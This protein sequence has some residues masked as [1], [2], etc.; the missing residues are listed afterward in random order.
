MSLSD[1][2]GES[3]PNSM[4][5]NWFG[6]IELPHAAVAVVLLD[7]TLEDLP[8]Y[9]LCDLRIDYLP[10]FI[11]SGIG[12]TKLQTHFK[13]RL[14]KNLCNILKFNYLQIKMR[15]LTHHY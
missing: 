14:L 13:S 1:S 10:S 5:F 4:C 11:V 3:W 2:Q 15:I 8:G 9:E 7:E 6:T 12:P